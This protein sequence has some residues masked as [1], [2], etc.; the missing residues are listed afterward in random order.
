MRSKTLPPNT[1]LTVSVSGTAPLVT[2]QDTGAGDAGADTSGADN[3]QNPSVNSRADTG[4]GA[5]TATATAMPARLD[6]L[7]WV[8]VAGFGALL[9]WA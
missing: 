4:A 6:S 8:L 3:S 9:P 1:P 7:K 5:A 2:D